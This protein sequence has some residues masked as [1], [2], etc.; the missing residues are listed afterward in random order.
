MRGRDKLHATF[1]EDVRQ[2]VF[3]AGAGCPTCGMRAPILLLALA[4]SCTLF[5]QDT[6]HVRSHDR[7]TIVTDPAAGVRSFPARVRFPPRSV[8]LR[9]VLLTVTFACPDS[10][11]CAEWDYLDHI[12][13]HPL[14]TTDTIEVARM[15]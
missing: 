6:L 14:G 4:L 3:P 15:L 10:L 11:R 1:F 8:D 12:L 9:Q 5:A 13:V 7:A 2:V